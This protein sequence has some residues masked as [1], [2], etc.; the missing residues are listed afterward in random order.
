MA[1]RKSDN[2]RLVFMGTPDF[3]VPV[4]NSLVTAGYD[5]V[6]V[7]SQPP[8]ATGRGQKLKKTPIHLKAQELG[9]K[10]RTPKS[11]GSEEEVLVLESLNVDCAVVVAYGLLLPESILA[12][13]RFGCLNI[14]A[15]LLPKWRGAAPIQ[16]AILSGDSE[17][18]VT[19]MRM[20]KGLDTGAILMAEKTPITNTTTGESLHNELS[21]IGAN[22]IL[23]ALGGLKGALVD[24]KAQPGH[25]I[26][27]AKKLERL[28][29]HINW[30]RPA[31]EIE[32]LIRAFTP[33]PGS[34]FE[35]G[36][37]R[38]KILVAEIVE[39]A[40]EPGTVLDQYLTIACG[41]GGLRLKVIQRAGKVPMTTSNFLRGFPLP[42]GSQLY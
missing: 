25:G 17:T 31:I 42:I 1:D 13:P 18:G 19:I 40:G 38:I 22:L 32:R 24:Q 9:I 30:K 6:C 4:L 39:G 29:G 27:Y 8:R 11:L 3:S 34:W 20:D 15:S 10:V 36:N 37:E 35:I 41:E 16:R 28:E 2:L 23:K 5:I 14:H 21:K 7:Y 33:W 12:M 26:T